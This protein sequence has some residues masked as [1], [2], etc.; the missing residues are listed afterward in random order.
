M[1]PS[2]REEL[3]EAIRD[4][5]E[6]KSVN[7]FYFKR[8]MARVISG[9][10]EAVFSWACINFL[11]GNL[12]PASTGIGAVTQTHVNASFGTLDLGGSSTQIAFF[13]PNED[14][15]EGL[16]RLQIG[17]QR[18]WNVYTK[19]FLQFGIN[20]SRKRMFRL[21]ANNAMSALA[22]AH[23]T[24]SMDSETLLNASK[25]VDIGPNHVD[26]AL[27]GAR[28]P[29]AA[30][31]QLLDKQRTLV[32]RNPCFHQ[33]WEEN[34]TNLVLDESNPFAS[35]VNLT[36]RGP[37]KQERGSHVQLNL[38]LQVLR[39]LMEKDANAYCNV[40]YHG[41]CSIGGAYQPSLPT[42]EYR[43][44]Y[45]TSTY[46]QPWTFLRL[47]PE[48]VS[49]E[50]FAQRASEICSMTFEETALY[51]QRWNLAQKD[52]K[53]G[54]LNQ[55]FCFMA[56]YTLVLLEDGY[57]FKPQD[58]IST[59]DKINGFATGWALGAVIHEINNLPWE[60]EVAS[61]Q[62]PWGRYVLSACIGMIIGAAATI[63]VSSDLNATI[64][65]ESRARR[66]A[67][68]QSTHDGAIQMTTHAAISYSNDP[69]NVK[70]QANGSS[71]ETNWKQKISQWNPFEGGQ[72]G[73]IPISEVTNA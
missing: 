43:H 8:D 27:G 68:F 7:P 47:P 25:G 73:Y 30:L 3:L 60:L 23:S 11:K 41:E 54:A 72:A 16:Y 50:L 55:Y 19:S 22:Y 62:S 21:L 44:F 71:L 46:E 67:Q 38:C 58:R 26:A 6:D 48:N 51:V 69:R 12:I 49:L 14:Y 56:S 59:I 1:T 34:V 52:E 17:G 9:E 5:F 2:S 4:L 32:L 37:W 53:L 42:G 24:A 66:V 33:G 20:S 45:A 65:G 36:V 61:Q 28:M 63:Y 10:E 13:L 29:L 70:S 40:V 35:T 39:P 18:Y 15:M 31:A 57:G 64:L